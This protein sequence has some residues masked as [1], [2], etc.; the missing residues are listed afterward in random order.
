MTPVH[1]LTLTSPVPAP[2][3]NLA[4]GSGRMSPAQGTVAQGTGTLPLSQRGSAQG[5]ELGPVPTGRSLS[6]GVSGVAILEVLGP[7]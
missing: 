5:Q 3:P 7:E 1:G 6:S 2:L 4:Q